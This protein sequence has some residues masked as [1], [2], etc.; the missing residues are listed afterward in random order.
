VDG[1]TYVFQNFNQKLKFEMRPSVSKLQNIRN[2]MVYA[3]IGHFIAFIAIL[4]IIVIKL[5]NAQL[6][7]AGLLFIFNI[8]FNL[9]PLL[10]QQQNKKRI[11]GLLK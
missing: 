8:I 9:H 10:L 7:Y 6:A 5:V 4:I 2:E 11:D 1:K 3:E